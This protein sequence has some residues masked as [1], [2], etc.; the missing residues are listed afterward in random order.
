MP[1]AIGLI[2]AALETHEPSQG[3]S[4]GRSTEC[5]NYREARSVS[6]R[7]HAAA[8]P[9]ARSPTPTSQISWYSASTSVAVGTI[10]LLFGEPDARAAC[11]IDGTA[12]RKT[13]SSMPNPSSVGTR[14]SLVT[15]CSASGM[16]IAASMSAAPS[17][18]RPISLAASAYRLTAPPAEKAVTRGSSIALHMPC[19]MW[20]LAPSGLLMPW[21]SVTLELEKAMP[22]SHEP[23]SIAS[24][25]A[26]SAGELHAV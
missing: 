10:G 5:I 16:P 12:L 9:R 3:G 18:Q 8:S 26:P 7:A 19:G 11:A 22:A 2:V 15:R 23:S 13:A 1:C 17:S 4:R 21:I 6:P 20:K 24:R 25:A 14:K